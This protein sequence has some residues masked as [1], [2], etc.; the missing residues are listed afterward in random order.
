MECHQVFNSGSV[1]GAS[2]Q[3]SSFGRLRKKGTGPKRDNSLASSFATIDFG[4]IRRA[5]NKEYRVPSV[6]LPV[7]EVRTGN[8]D[9]TIHMNSIKISP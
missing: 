5:F 8:Y 4:K 3:K 6:E 1:K 2:G 7:K 9:R